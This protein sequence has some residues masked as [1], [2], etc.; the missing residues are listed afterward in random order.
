M[1]KLAHT[2]QP[3]RCRLNVLGALFAKRGKRHISS[4]R[5]FARVELSAATRRARPAQMRA[6]LQRSAS[7]ASRAEMA[8]GW[9]HSD[10]PV[11]AGA[12]RR[13][14]PMPISL[15]GPA[16]CPA[17]VSFPARLNRRTG[18]ASP[19]SKGRGVAGTTRFGTG[20]AMQQERQ[21]SRHTKNKK[22]VQAESSCPHQHPEPKLQLLSQTNW[23]AKL[24]VCRV[25]HKQQPSNQTC[26]TA[27][28]LCATAG[29]TS[30]KAHQTAFIPAQKGAQCTTR[31]FTA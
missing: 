19:G 28:V 16:G 29:T 13:M 1:Q 14:G 26:P 25:T 2:L 4:K 5:T 10:G 7:S 27:S 24:G 20:L 22:T 11:L 23:Q 12:N 6:S 3:L 17:Q 15:A 18:R 30:N 31:I 8:S 9:L 21:R